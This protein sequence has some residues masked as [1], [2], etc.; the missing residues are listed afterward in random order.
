[1]LSAKGYIYI[2]TCI[3]MYYVY[4]RMSFSVEQNMKYLYGKYQILKI[5]LKNHTCHDQDLLAIF[6]EITTHAQCHWSRLHSTLDSEL[7]VNVYFAWRIDTNNAM[8]KKN[9]PVIFWRSK[10]RSVLGRFFL[11]WLTLS[12][13]SP[14]W[15]TGY[16]FFAR[17]HN[18][19]RV[20]EFL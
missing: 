9:E 18:P 17:M 14:M 20:S 4:Q 7:E 12:T 11:S 15:R 19:V 5:S 13:V 16:G 6:R 2:I 8:A 10:N 3:S 1:M